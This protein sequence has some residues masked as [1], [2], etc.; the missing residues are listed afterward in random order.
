MKMSMTA[1]ST[2]SATAARI[3]ASDAVRSQE[4]V[5]SDLEEE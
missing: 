5:E 1:S 4:A 2:P 3:D